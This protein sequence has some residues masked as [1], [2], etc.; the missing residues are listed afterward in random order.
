MDPL[1]VWR[2]REHAT[3]PRRNYFL[4]DHDGR[5]SLLYEV[6]LRRGEAV[7]E[8]GCLEG[9]A[10]ADALH[11]LVERAEEDYRHIW[12]RE[13]G[14]LPRNWVEEEAAALPERYGDFL[15]ASRELCGGETGV[16]LRSASVGLSG[17]VDRVDGGGRPAIIRT[18]AAPSNGVWRADR[19]Q[20][21]AYSLLLSEESG[22]AV[23]EA[24]VDYAAEHEVRATGITP[25]HRREL[26]TVRDRAR[27][28]VED[29]KLPSKRNEKLC[30]SCDF[31]D[32]CKQEPSSLKERFFG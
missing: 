13:P 12:G 16:T 24:V 9:P 28:V 15:I 21:A 26:L 31:E 27:R 6:A 4:D 30:P 22:E 5:R 1:P 3:C 29:R 23:D 20:A 14:P 8:A 32:E 11:E 17:R 2:I 7:E 25:F 10:L 18:G 19:A